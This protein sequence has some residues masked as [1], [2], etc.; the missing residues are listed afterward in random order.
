[1]NDPG[2]MSFVKETV[3][4]LLKGYDIRLRPDFGGEWGVRGRCG[5]EART[6]ARAAWAREGGGVRFRQRGAWGCGWGW[7]MGGGVGWGALLLRPL[8]GQPWQP[9]RAPRARARARL[10]SVSCAPRRTPGLRGDEH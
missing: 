7:G 8:L 6:R 9:P 3:D 2:N 10:I 4:K 1:M 5:G